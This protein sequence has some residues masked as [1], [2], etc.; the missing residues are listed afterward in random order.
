MGLGRKGI[1][2]SLSAILLIGV[3]FV[4]F[5]PAAQRELSP[6][7]RLQVTETISRV[8]ALETS[9]LEVWIDHTSRSALNQM[10]LQAASGTQ[11]PFNSLADVQQAFQQCIF[12]QC[13]QTPADGSGIERVSARDHLTNLDSFYQ[14][15]L[16]YETAS[17]ELVDMSI[18]P[19][20]VRTVAVDATFNLEFID[21]VNRVAIRRQVDVRRL[22]P[23]TG[24][25]D[26]LARREG[27]D[28]RIVI[29]RST[30]I[31]VE[32]FLEHARQGTY[33]ATD[34]SYPGIPFLNRFIRNPQPVFENSIHFVF[35]PGHYGT[36]Q[37]SYV[38]FYALPDQSS[39]CL[40]G[41]RD[42][43]SN[44]VIYVDTLFQVY[45]NLFG[46]VVDFEGTIVGEN[47]D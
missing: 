40:L 16:G 18:A 10:A 20:G 13:P 24:L 38:D 30:Y 43:S 17:I 31:G 22:V 15:E 29:G 28:G 2:L 5:A 42:S 45:Y 44:Q 36:E 11:S 34:Q 9:E 47:C 25:I 4:I 32:Q 27:L 6:D 23:I 35:P 7:S 1:F 37:R 19:A 8:S 21:D 33:A 41:L 3:L 46:E 14:N 12:E 39:D 26:P